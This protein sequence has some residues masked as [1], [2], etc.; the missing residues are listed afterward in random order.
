MK[1][2]HPDNL[3]AHHQRYRNLRTGFFHGFKVTGVL[4]YIGGINRP[5]QPGSRAGDAF[6]HGH[7]VSQRHL[8]S[9]E[10][11]AHKKFLLALIH[12]QDGAVLKLKIIAD[13][14]KNAI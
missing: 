9:S 2:E 11:G 12:E 10:V 5:L 3:I 13:D 4:A 14:G 6:C 7:P 8:A 1:V